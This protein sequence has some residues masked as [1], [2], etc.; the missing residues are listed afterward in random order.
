MNSPVTHPGRKPIPS[1]APNFLVA[2]SLAVSNRLRE[3]TQKAAYF[4]LA[5]DLAATAAVFFWLALLALAVFC[6]VFFW[7][8]FGDLSPIILI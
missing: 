5:V 7:L 8:D 6:D 4:F 1:P 3:T 2:A